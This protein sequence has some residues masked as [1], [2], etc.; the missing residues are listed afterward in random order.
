MIFH[1]TR[2]IAR[3]IYSGF[4]FLLFFLPNT[5]DAQL[6]LLDKK[7]STTCVD[8]EFTVM[9]HPV[10]GLRTLLEK[11]VPQLFG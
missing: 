5:A 11:M 10:K 4:F 9:V 6:A 3:F 7:Q 8:R 2:S 1:T